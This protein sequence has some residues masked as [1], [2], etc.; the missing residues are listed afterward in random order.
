M[1]SNCSESRRLRSV[2]SVCRRRSPDICPE[3]YQE[4]ATTVASVMMRANSSAVVG[5]RLVLR[6]PGEAK[7]LD[8]GVTAGLY[9][10]AAPHAGARADASTTD[11]PGRRVRDTTRSCTAPD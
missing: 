2:S 5:D 10:D 1:R 7:G 9:Q 4:Y 3:M 6:E 8:V 11:R